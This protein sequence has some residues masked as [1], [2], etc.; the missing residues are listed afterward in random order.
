MSAP[1]GRGLRPPDPCALPWP[2]QEPDLGWETRPQATEAWKR[3]LRAGGLQ[4]RPLPPR[5]VY[6]A[7]LTRSHR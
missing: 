4:V 6:A 1:H 2:P 3:S 5:S 7:A